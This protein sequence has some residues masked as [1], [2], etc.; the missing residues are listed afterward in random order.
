MANVKLMKEKKV[1]QEFMEQLSLD[2]GKVGY[3]LQ[4]TLKALE[5]GAVEDLILWDNLE[6]ERYV[7][8]NPSTKEEKVIHLSSS[9]QSLIEDHL[10]DST[11]A[12]PF[13]VI[14]QGPLLEWIANNYKD[15]GCSNLQLMTDNSSEGMQFVRGFG[16]VGCILRWK[17]DFLEPAHLEEDGVDDDDRDGS[18]SS[19]GFDEGDF[20]L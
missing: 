11:S 4:D 19:Y 7:L 18:C 12:S 10:I 6:V 15:F 17:V 5:C 13:E 9:D 14:D 20:G 1:L 16:G 2:T 3:T 8:R